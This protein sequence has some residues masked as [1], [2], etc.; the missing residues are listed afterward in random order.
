MPTSV[1]SD[2]DPKPPAPLQP[3]LNPLRQQ[4]LSEQETLSGFCLEWILDRAD[5]SKGR[6]S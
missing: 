1:P 5:I 6:P 4:A 3:R 2:R